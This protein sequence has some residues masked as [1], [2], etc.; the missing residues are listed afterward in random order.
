[1]PPEQELATIAEREAELAALQTSFDEY[2]ESSRLLEEELDAELEKVQKQLS[3]S[4]LANSNLMQQ[5]ENITPQLHQLEKA[6]SKANTKLNGEIELRRKAE[7]DQDEAEAKARACEGTIDALKEESD[8]AFQELAFREDEMDELKIMFEVEK[9]KHQEE[10]QL[11]RQE[12]EDMRHNIHMEW[13]KKDDEQKNVHSNG[14]QNATENG[15]FSIE[16]DE[17]FKKQ[18]EVLQ[19]KEDYIKSLEDELELVTEELIES[20]DEKAKLLSQMADKKRHPVAFDDDYDSD[21]LST[22]ASSV[23]LSIIKRTKMRKL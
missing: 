2:I 16:D 18:L 10:M 19:E 9:E 3:E 21:V 23:P 12:L 5:L 6:L 11:L 17:K 14:S 1:M 20:N 22:A 4:N 15:N 8:K 13:R 7:L